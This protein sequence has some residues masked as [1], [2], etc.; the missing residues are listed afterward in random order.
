[1]AATPNALKKAYKTVT[2]ED[3]PRVDDASYD[4]FRPWKDA[5][6][7]L[8]LS[9]QSQAVGA[10]VVSYA[11]KYGNAFA[12]QMLDAV[13]AEKDKFWRLAEWAGNLDGAHC[14]LAF[15]W[16]KAYSGLDMDVPR[17]KG[18]SE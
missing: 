17:P 7:D 16:M 14:R 8:Q 13:S 15:E 2:G 11:V 12:R 18:G 5:W 10:L 9:D 6:N 4:S 3:V 1:M